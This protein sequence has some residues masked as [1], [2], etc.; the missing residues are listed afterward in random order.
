MGT[1]R[2]L[3]AGVEIQDEFLRIWEFPH[4]E[5]LV[6]IKHVAS[7]GRNWLGFVRIETT[8]GMVYKVP[9]GYK[10]EIAVKAIQMAMASTGSA[11]SP[12]IG[13]I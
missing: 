2:W 5:D 8:G 6:L 4:Y 3:V 1:F 7:V 13:L 10:T 11:V 9:L 12:R